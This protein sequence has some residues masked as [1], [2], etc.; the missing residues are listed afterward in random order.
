MSLASLISD[1]NGS[2]PST[3]S[4]HASTYSRWHRASSG[5][6]HARQ[7]SSTDRRRSAL[8]ASSRMALTERWLE[9]AST[10]T[11]RSSLLAKWYSS[12]RSLVPRAAASGRRLSPI[13]PC[14]ST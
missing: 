1:A 2:S 13:R 11:T 3:P 12:I 9:T 6:L 14:S 8:G 10:V 7:R 4:A 5:V